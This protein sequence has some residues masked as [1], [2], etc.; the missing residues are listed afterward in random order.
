MMKETR[1]ISLRRPQGYG[2]CLGRWL[3]AAAIIIVLLGARAGFAAENITLRDVSF[4]IGQTNYRA[5][6]VEF[7][8]A[9][10]NE[11]QLGALFD[12]RASDSLD[13]RL[14]ELSATAV[15]VPELFA[16]WSSSDGRQSVTVRDLTLQ[17]I[18]RGK[19]ASASTRAIRSEGSFVAMLGIG[20]IA[21][22]DF[23]L[24]LSARLYQH[25]STI[26]EKDSDAVVGALDLNGLDLRSQGGSIV[27]ADRVSLSGVRAV[28]SADKAADG[29]SE[30]DDAQRYLSGVGT[31]TFVGVGADLVSDQ[32]GSE[33]LKFS[34]KNATLATEH[35]YNGLP[36]DVALTID[37]FRLLIPSPSEAQTARDLHDMGYDAVELSLQMSA[38]WNEANG[39][40]VSDVSLRAADAGSVVLRARLG[41]VSKEAF[42]SKAAVAESA[43]SKA[44]IKSLVVAVKDAGLFERILANEARKENRPAED[45]RRDFIFESG[46]AVAS[47][48]GTTPAAG[49]VARAVSD[50]IKRPGELE[51]SIK[52]KPP[53]GIGWVDLSAANVPG[54]MSDKLNISAKVR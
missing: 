38:S 39:E 9:N 25:P 48:L 3:A 12:A 19:A 15:N 35:P 2:L 18:V 54:T 36:T 16:E 11:Q 7:I 41:N 40:V 1:M 37:D 52:A 28:P 53:D 20:P 5:P 30:Q 46:A 32:V 42:S 31:I 27:H 43:S 10:L 24:A 50:F 29:K 51:I 33:R 17:N 34:M 4:R 22:T 44:T 21:V 23:D 13:K 6:Q 26:K 47:V 8:G 45:V 49:V 14:A